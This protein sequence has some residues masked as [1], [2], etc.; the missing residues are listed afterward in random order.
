[1]NRSQIVTTMATEADTS[2]ITAERTLEAFEVRVKAH[3]DEGRN[4]ALCGFGTFSQGLPSQK[5]GINPKTGTPIN[6]TT[7]HRPANAPSI[8]YDDL[9]G[10]I[11][12][13]TKADPATIRRALNAAIAVI[14]K[15]VSKGDRV[16]LYGFGSFQS[17]KRAARRGRNPRTGEAILIPATTVP[18]FKASKARNVGAKFAAGTGFK[19][20]VAGRRA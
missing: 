19:P 1:M 17:A 14:V 2:K 8:A 6:Y 3:N 15:S 11:A 16:N 7:Y 20:A 10:E 4:V 18:R 9:L 13:D 5:S 12:D